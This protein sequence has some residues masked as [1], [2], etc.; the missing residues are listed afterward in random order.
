M[1][2]LMISSGCYSDYGIGYLIE[3][4][5]PV[6]VREVA[7]RLDETKTKLTKKAYRMAGLFEENRRGLIKDELGP[8][9]PDEVIKYGLSYLGDL[10]LWLL[11]KQG[12]GVK[13]LE[14]EEINLDSPDEG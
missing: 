8:D 14:Y 13:V 10:F 7:K 5:H 11:K 9:V 6:K 12:V 4:D 2:I 3:T 1:A